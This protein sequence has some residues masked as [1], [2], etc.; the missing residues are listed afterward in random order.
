M[1]KGM[2]HLEKEHILIIEDDADI[3]EGIRILL[4]SENYTVSEAGDGRSG[5][6]TMSKD[7]DL[8]ILDVMMPGMSGI[9]VCKEIRSFSNV[10]VLFLTAKVQEA[11][12]L[13]GLMAG[14]DDYLTKPFSY[15]ELLGRIKAL[16]RRYK[17]YLGKSSSPETEKETYIEYGRIRINKTYNE[18]FVDEKEKDL[19]DIEYHILLLMM[20]NPRRIFSAQNLYESV[21]NEPYFYSCNSTVMVHIRKLRVKI[22]PDPQN[23]RYITTVWGN[24]YRFDARCD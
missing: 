18:L 20:E 6:E 24:G 23:P 16:I 5:L 2:K 7:I 22:E 9:Q 19:S 15:G 17:I 3:R 1:A 14:G 4:E 11:D 8:V 10:P 13:T 21:W 12:K